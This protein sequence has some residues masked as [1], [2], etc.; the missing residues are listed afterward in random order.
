MKSSESDSSKVKS[1]LRSWR[2]SGT[3]KFFGWLNW[4][5]LKGS[6]GFPLDKSTAD[7]GFGRGRRSRK[8]VSTTKP[9]GRPSR[10]DGGD[11]VLDLIYQAAKAVHDVEARAGETERY[12]RTI[13]ET[14]VKTL[15]R[16]VKRIQEL[17]AEL[18]SSR[19]KSPPAQT[20][21]PGE[22]VRPGI[23]TLVACA[24]ERIAAITTYPRKSTM[25]PVIADQGPFNIGWTEILARAD[26]ALS[27][28]SARSPNKEFCHKNHIASQQAA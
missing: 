20:R 12:T 9:I 22:I 6:R 4:N 2:T 7:H 8:P 21:M 3:F 14:A 13:A 10:F 18:E 25:M 19:A 11:A 27:E 16:A 17:E 5:Q 26:A 24:C 1:S 28:T 15:K 23:I